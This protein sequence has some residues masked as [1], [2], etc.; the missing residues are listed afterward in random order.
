[1]NTAEARQGLIHRTKSLMR[2]LA[3]AG[4]LLVGAAVLTPTGVFAQAREELIV[5][6]GQSEVLDV[7]ARYTDLMIADPEIADVLPLS[8]RS[9][10][11]VGKKPAPRRSASTGRA[12]GC[13][14]WP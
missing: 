14:R 7:G 9:I 4:L 6:A 10:Y 12:S 1:M 2:G 13:C 11:V 3:F 5:P 8:D